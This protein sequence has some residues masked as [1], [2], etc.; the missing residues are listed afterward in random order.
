MMTSDRDATQTVLISGGAGRLGS[1]FVR[2]LVFRGHKVCVLENLP[3]VNV[4]EQLN[5]NYL[6]SLEIVEGDATQP[7]DIDR[8]ISCC[9]SRFGRLTAAVHC[10]YPRTPQWGVGFEELKVE[11]LSENISKQLGGAIMFSQRIIRAFRKQKG[12]NLVHVSSILGIAPPKFRHY[13]GLGMTSPVEYSAI[14]AG[15]ISVTRYL[16]KYCRQEGIRVNCISPGGIRD[17]HDPEFQKRYR[18]DCNSEGLLNGDDVVGALM[19]LLSPDSRFVTG[20]NIV[21]DD[22]WSL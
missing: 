11:E 2:A 16:A 3:E 4:F 21:V 9:V 8:A 22:G 5:S 18:D 15:T 14:K 1:A 10:A 13:E 7:D 12:G 6:E 17:N 19:F 20:Q